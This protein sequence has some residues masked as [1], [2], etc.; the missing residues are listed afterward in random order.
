MKK[1]I[2]M[3][4]LVLVI[5]TIITIVS[6]ALTVSAKVVN[7]VDYSY[8]LSHKVDTSVFDNLDLT[9]YT[10]DD[11]TNTYYLCRDVYIY[12]SNGLEGVGS[13]GYSPSATSFF[14]QI[15]KYITDGASWCLKYDSSGKWYYRNSPDDYADDWKNYQ[16]YSIF[17]DDIYIKIDGYV[18]FAWKELGLIV[19][20]P[21]FTGRRMYY[22]FNSDLSLFSSYIYNNYHEDGGDPDCIKSIFGIK[23]FRATFNYIYNEQHYSISGHLQVF[24]EPY[25][26]K[27]CFAIS[28]KEVAYVVCNESGTDAYLYIPHYITDNDGSYY[29]QLSNKDI[30][31]CASLTLEEFG[32]YSTYLDDHS[33]LEYSEIYDGGEQDSV[34]LQLLCDKEVLT[35]VIDTDCSH[36]TL[37]YSD[38]YVICADCG[39]STVHLHSWGEEYQTLNGLV[40][41]CSACGASENIECSGHQY[42]IRESFD[43]EKVGFIRTSVCSLCGFTIAENIFDDVDSSIEYPYITFYSDDARNT[44]SKYS[45]Y[46]EDFV[47]FV[48]NV[49]CSSSLLD[50][51]NIKIY[52][53]SSEKTICISDADDNTLYCKYSKAASSFDDR[54]DFVEEDLFDPWFLSFDVVSASYVNNIEDVLR[55]YSVNSSGDVGGDNTGTPGDS[56]GGSENTENSDSDN[57]SSD[58]EFNIQKIIGLLM[59]TV[60]VAGGVYL[61]LNISTELKKKAIK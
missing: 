6:A 15:N 49:K 25:T 59:G 21:T 17:T 41:I 1:I 3:L 10:Y 28:G 37:I 33:V 11:A 18:P 32:H 50:G 36:N 58:E 29:A 27:V 48:G 51:K 47:F 53:S 9:S 57:K 22:D 20:E 14:V 7:D 39:Y 44:I 61:V 8:K 38:G 30:D 35:L 2:K 16:D 13:I 40:H 26:Q 56:T 4:S 19:F 54:Y 45:S 23:S 60:V 52:Y 42:K 46:T 31:F 12:L 34:Y 5:I 55:A 24:Y 43:S